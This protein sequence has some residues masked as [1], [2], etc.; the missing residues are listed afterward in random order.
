MRIALHLSLFLAMTAISSTVSGQELRKINTCFE[1]SLAA[2]RLSQL[3]Q[4][5]GHCDQVIEDKATPAD[6]RGQ[7]FAQRGLMHARRWTI[8]ATP[9]VAVQGIADI[10]EALGLH[11][12]A[13]GRRHQLLLVRAQLYVATGQTRRAAADYGA[14]LKDDPNNTVAKSGRDRLGSM[15]GL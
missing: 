11:T 9:A 1:E 13:N 10:T 2:L 12:P 7:A 6:R 3:D 15:E 5:I 14:I 4:G 8:V